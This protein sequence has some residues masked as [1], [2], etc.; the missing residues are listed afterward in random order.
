MATHSRTL[1]WKIP[2]TEKPG[3]LQSM[4]SQSRTRLSNFTSHIQEEDFS[5]GVSTRILCLICKSFHLHFLQPSEICHLYCRKFILGPIVERREPF[6]TGPSPLT[7]IGRTHHPC[8][9]ISISISVFIPTSIS[10]SVSTSISAFISITTFM[11][12]SLA[13]QM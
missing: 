4:G 3:R 12:P 11:A 7:V 5:S 10:I 6:T 13:P 2:W 1:A 8:I 9:S